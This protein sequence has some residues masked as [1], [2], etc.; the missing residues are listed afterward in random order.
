M[1]PIDR[2][3]RS[4][5]EVREELKRFLTR[6][7]GRVEAEDLVQDVWLNLRERGDPT[8]WRTPRA[9]LFTTASN[10]ATDAYRRTRTAR[11]V[12]SGDAANAEAVSPQAG[13]EEQVAANARV[14]QLIGALQQLPPACRDAFLLNRLEGLTHTAI[15]A[16][17]GVSTKTVQRYVERALTHCLQ[18]VEP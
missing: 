11:R 17:L 1:S 6:R 8:S 3:T 16:R 5:A 9:V 15:A 18:V 12:F 4:F 13:P 7:A 10:L 14:A 2:L